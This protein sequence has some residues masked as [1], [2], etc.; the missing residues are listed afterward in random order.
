MTAHT[1][2][3]NAKALRNAVRLTFLT[4]SVALCGAGAL[5]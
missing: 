2:K 1:K 3:E 5:L 4:D